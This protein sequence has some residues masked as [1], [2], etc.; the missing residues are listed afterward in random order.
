[1]HIFNLKGTRNVWWPSFPEPVGELERSL[2]PIAA[3]IWEEN[4]RRKEKDKREVKARRR[5]G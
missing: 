4:G 3:K 5:K 2:D 1:M